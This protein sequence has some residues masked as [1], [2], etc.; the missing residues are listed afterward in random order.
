MKNTYNSEGQFSYLTF[1]CM[2]YLYIPKF[3]MLYFEL[4]N[5]VRVDYSKLNVAIIQVIIL[6][7]P[8]TVISNPAERYK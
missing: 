4:W 5:L 8:K 7:K 3:T 6:Q 1:A 2:I